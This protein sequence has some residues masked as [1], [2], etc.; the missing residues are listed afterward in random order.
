MA[1]VASANRVRPLLFHRL[2]SHHPALPTPEGSS[3]LRFQV[4]PDVSIR[5]TFRGLR[6]GMRNSAPSCP[7]AG[8]TSRRCKLHFMLRADA[9][10]LLLEGLQRFNTASH[11]TAL[12]ACYLAACPLPGSD[13]HR[14]ADDDFSGHTSLCWATGTEQDAIDMERIHSHFDMIA[15]TT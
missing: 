11:P 1:A 15:C 3:V 8:S 9:L 7:L 10:R 2:L 12:V 14:L 5:R 4:L 6:F 13:F